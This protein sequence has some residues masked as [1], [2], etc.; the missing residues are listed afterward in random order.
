MLQETQNEI[1]VLSTLN[2]PNIIQYYDSFYE[3]KSVYISMEYATHGNLA[4]YMYR[5]QNFL[6][7]QNVSQ[8]FNN[9]CTKISLVLV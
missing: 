3:N 7:P 8:I 2:H 1:K 4:Q 6:L 9:E 5:R